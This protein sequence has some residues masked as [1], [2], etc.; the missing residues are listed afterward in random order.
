MPWIGGVSGSILE[1]IVTA[2]SFSWL[3]CRSVRA[4]SDN[5]EFC[6]MTKEELEAVGELRKDSDTWAGHQE[7]EVIN[8]QNENGLWI[9]KIS[10]LALI[11]AASLIGGGHHGLGELIFGAYSAQA[12]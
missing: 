3:S 2:V 11:E 7:W 9:T 5:Y 1:R 8:K 12:A 10:G 4:G 6:Q